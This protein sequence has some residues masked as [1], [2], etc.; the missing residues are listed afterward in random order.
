VGQRCQPREREPVMRRRHPHLCSSP[1]GQRASCHRVRRTHS[2]TSGAGQAAALSSDH[3]SVVR[4]HTQGSCALVRVEAMLVSPY[5]HP[6]SSTAVRTVVTKPRTLASLVSR[7]ARTKLG[8][9]YPPA[10][11]TSVSSPSPEPRPLQALCSKA[12]AASSGRWAGLRSAL[13]VGTEYRWCSLC[14]AC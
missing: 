5:I 8:Q 10:S 11:V 2:S 7:L 3:F 4:H 13:L 1:C 6:V 14:S 9:S 12:I